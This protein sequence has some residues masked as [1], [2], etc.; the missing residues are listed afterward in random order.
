[1][2][3]IGAANRVRTGDLLV[4]NETFYQ[5]NY[6]RTIIL[7]GTKGLEPPTYSV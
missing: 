4:G 3:F 1:M 5:L 7:V 2:F 6:R